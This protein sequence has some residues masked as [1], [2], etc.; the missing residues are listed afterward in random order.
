MRDGGI[1][2]SFEHDTP[3]GR[4]VFYSFE[5]MQTFVQLSIAGRS[6]LVGGHL[7][8]LFPLFCFFGEGILLEFQILEGSLHPTHHYRMLC[9]QSD[10]PEDLE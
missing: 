6:V 4:P 8:S 5:T 9:R 10:V 7:E 1:R 3:S 2:G